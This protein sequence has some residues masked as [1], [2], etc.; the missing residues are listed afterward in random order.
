MST[1]LPSASGKSTR[2]G[3]AGCVDFLRTLTLRIAWMDATRRV[4][5]RVGKT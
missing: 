4:A 3:R 5:I 1:G 2:N